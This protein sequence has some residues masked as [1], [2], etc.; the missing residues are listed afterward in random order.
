MV[1]FYQLASLY[2]SIKYPILCLKLTLT[3]KT[4][5][6]SRYDLFYSAKDLHILIMVCWTKIKVMVIFSGFRYGTTLVLDIQDT[7][8]MM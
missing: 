1:R 5:I 6:I 3:S 7:M 8:L 2:V 4:R